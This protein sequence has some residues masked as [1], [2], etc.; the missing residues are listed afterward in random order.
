MKII[1]DNLAT[2]Y[3]DQGQG[4]VILMLH[5]WGGSLHGFDLLVSN[6]AQKHR[7]VR[8]DL[9]GFGGTDAPTETWNLDNYLSFAQGFI[10]KLDLQ[11]EILVG[12]SFG[13]R[14]AIKG[15][16]TGGLTA[17]KLIL[18]ASAGI[19]K[20]RTLKNAL[21]I[22]IT[23][24]G[25]LIFYLPPLLFWRDRLRKKVYR[26]LGSDYLDA[27]Q[28]RQ[29]YLK[30]I[31][32]DLSAWA[33]KVSVPTLLIWGA[34]DETTPLSDGERLTALIPGAKLEVIE[35][36]DHDVHQQKPEQV[37]ELINQFL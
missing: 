36:A 7:V 5:G 16:A 1:V 34:E 31:A 27:G 15:L 10:K 19:A 32:E 33:K 30:I 37:L 35:G 21:M 24:I 12:H 29:T 6:L 8:L 11:V 28:L 2:E 20:R 22:T 13:G 4:P 18:I 17:K 26:F 23:K 3:A 25:G 14:M 9:P